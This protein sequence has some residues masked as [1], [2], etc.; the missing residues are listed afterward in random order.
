[1]ALPCGVADLPHLG[2]IIGER[3]KARDPA[4]GA[5]LDQVLNDT[6]LAAKFRVV[7]KLRRSSPSVAYSTASQVTFPAILD[8]FLSVDGGVDPLYGMTLTR[9][10]KT[11]HFG[12]AGLK[13][14]GMESVEAILSAVRQE[15][16]ISGN[17]SV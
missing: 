2:R 1:M 17:Y 12:F 11:V 3:Q 14:S 9:E 4:N 7:D 5:F 8:A 13:E 15:A 16:A 6:G 10:G